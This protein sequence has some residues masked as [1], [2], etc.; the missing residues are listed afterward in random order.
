M[1]FYFPHFAGNEY[2][3]AI[4]QGTRT[5]TIQSGKIGPDGRLSIQ[6]PAD[7]TDYRG[8]VAWSLKGGGGMNFVLAG[9]NISISC[10]EK[11]PSDNN[12]L[13]TGSPENTLLREYSSKQSLLFSKTDVIFRGREL[14]RN[15]KNL[16]AV[17]DREAE[18]L[19]NSYQQFMQTVVES[20]TYVSDYLRI[21]SFLSGIASRLYAPGEENLRGEDLRRFVANDLNMDVLYTSGRWNHAISATFDLFPDKKDFAGAMV[22]NLKRTRSPQ[23]FIALATD[24]VTICE[25][26]GWPEAEDIIV[27]Y[28]MESGRIQNPQGPLR[29]AFGMYKVKSGTKALPV[30]GIN[31]L[32]NSIL[33]FYESGCGN[34]QTQIDELKKHYASLQT[35]GLKVISIS[36]DMD[37]TVF[38]SFSQTFPWPDRLCDYKGFEGENFINYSIYGTPTLFLIDKNGMIVGRYARLEEMKDRVK[39]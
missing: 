22:N 26:F 21:N 27:Y 14:Y 25:Q 20:K 6:L 23:V 18:Q 9:E 38:K 33:I 2:A 39:I 28:L 8:I 12:I 31:K 1:N 4:Y 7:K 5:D 32:S 34:C 24:L 29:V 13:Y 37:S 19:N 35:Q 36:S 16:F 30:K 3:L 10:T 11:I 15:D 17:F